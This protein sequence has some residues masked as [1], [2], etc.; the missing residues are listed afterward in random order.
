MELSNREK[1][2]LSIKHEKSNR[3]VLIFGIFLMV[4]SIGLIPYYIVKI[5]KIDSQWEKSSLQIDSIEPVTELENAIKLTLEN[6]IKYS[7]EISFKYHYTDFLNK[8]GGLFMLGLFAIGIYIKT[9]FY[10]QIIRKLKN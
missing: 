1:A 9:S 7:K 10:I 4:L 3:W 6:S 5:D 2:A 8:S